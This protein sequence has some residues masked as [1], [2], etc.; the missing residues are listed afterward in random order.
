VWGETADEFL[1][2]PYRNKSEGVSSLSGR[3]E[4]PAN[5]EVRRGV[6][7]SERSLVESP[8]EPVRKTSFGTEAGQH[9][10]LVQLAK[11][12][13]RVDPEPPEHID[14][15]GQAEDLHRKVAEPLR[16]RRARHDLA[17]SS[18][19]PGC[20]RPVGYPHPA[21]WF[22]GCS[23]GRVCNSHDSRT[24]GITDLRRERSLPA[25]VTGRS[26]G[27]YRA[28]PW[29]GELYQGSES[30]NCYDDR[31]EAA[32][33]ACCLLAHHD[34]LRTTC[35][36]LSAALA[37]AHPF[38]PG[39]GRRGD[40]PVAGDDHC[41]TV[42][43]PGGDK[44]PVRAPDDKGANRGCHGPQAGSRNRPRLGRLAAPRPPTSA[45]SWRALSNP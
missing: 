24:S 20:E 43:E 27:G 45:S 18:G 9:R 30:R 37:K 12:T 17:L 25:E 29:P 14:E 35:L 33:V 16:C 1:G 8:G 19:E 44:G 32:S 7:K 15:S 23:A 39:S 6:A 40:H 42:R 13:Q 28:G 2:E 26:T 36:C 10:R 38:G 31:F 3:V 5:S 34:E 11:L 4:L 21:R 41:R 22:R